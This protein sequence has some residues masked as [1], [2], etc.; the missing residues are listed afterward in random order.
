M[1]DV[2]TV[3]R[4]SPMVSVWTFCCKVKAVKCQNKA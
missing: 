3:S 2:H 1:H 4:M